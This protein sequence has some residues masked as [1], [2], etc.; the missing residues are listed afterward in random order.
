MI[1]RGNARQDIFFE[2]GDRFRFYLLMQEGV[3][4]YQYRVHAFCL[5]SNHIHLLVQVSDV[6]L[7]RIM[8]NLSFRYTRW[9]NW[10]QGKS[11]H[12]FQGRF[13]AVLVD[14]DAYLAELVRYLHLNPV[15]V[16]IAVDPLAYPWSSHHAYCGKETIPWLCTDFV[17]H[18]FDK[19]S[20]TARKRFGGFVLDGLAGGHRP[21]FHGHGSADS[22]LL[23]DESFAERVLN[24]NDGIPPGRMGIRELVSSACR[25]Y[26]VDE[27]AL[28]ERT[29]RASRLR[30][31]IAWLALD[32]EGCTLT[33]VASLTGRDLSTLSSAVR[34][35]RAKAITDSSLLEKRRAIM[36]TRTHVLPRSPTFEV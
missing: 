30:A 25:H 2:D 20:D 13:K 11:G 24:D 23:G 35:L 14:A 31:M 27:D 5:M 10:R 26:G 7:S 34:K 1:L 36:E 4:R 28:G 29:H 18:G 22:R 8:Q 9:A 33:E 21:E 16:G 6:P 15:R 17:L 3:E 32:T 12:L 19:H